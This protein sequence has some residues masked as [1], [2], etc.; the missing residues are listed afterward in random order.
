MTPDMA[1]MAMSAIVH[2]V[3]TTR[4]VDTIFV[5]PSLSKLYSVTA[6]LSG[7]SKITALPTCRVLNKDAVDEAVLALRAVLFIWSRLQSL[8]QPPPPSAAGRR[9][10][11]ARAGSGSSS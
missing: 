1:K 5:S 11:T 8:S 2:S 4:T 3:F 10:S 6:H 7:Y 9:D